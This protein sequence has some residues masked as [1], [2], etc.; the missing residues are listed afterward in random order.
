MAGQR[1]EAP[2]KWTTGGW[3]ST[4]TLG[5][6]G[7]SLQSQSTQHAART[8]WAGCLSDRRGQLRAPPTATRFWAFDTVAPGEAG[9]V[10]ARRYVDGQPACR[11]G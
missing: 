2:V 1:V 10:G 7:P 6:L 11:Q 4:L 3:A 9:P 5:V 8:C